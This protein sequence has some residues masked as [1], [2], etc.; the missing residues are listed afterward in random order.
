M[1][2]L[3]EVAVDALHA[4]IDMDAEVMCTAFSNFFGS[5]VGHRLALRRRAGA[6][7][8]ALED[9]AEVPAVAVVVGELRVLELRVELGHPLRGTPGRP[10]GRGSPLLG[11][12]VVDLAD[13]GGGRVLLLLRAT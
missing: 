4:E 8:V 6:L 3:R 5:F 11:I 12:A 7:A 10:T 2:V 13:L 9:R 1:R